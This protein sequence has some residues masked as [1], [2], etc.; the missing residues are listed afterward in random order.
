MRTLVLRLERGRPLKAPFKLLSRKRGYLGWTGD[1]GL[2]L[3]LC[4]KGEGDIYYL[5]GC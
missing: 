1:Y 4:R 3:T 2:M 5:K